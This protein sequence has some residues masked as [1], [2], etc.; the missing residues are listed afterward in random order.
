M[1]KKNL[2]IKKI[3]KSV[4]SITNRIESFFNF[5]KENIS[6]KKKFSKTLKTVDKRIF[7]IAATIVITITSYFLIPS[8]YDKDKIKAELENQIYDQYNLKV[9]FDQSLKYGLFPKPHFYKIKPFA[10]L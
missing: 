5:F 3:N 10:T 9:K 7:F 8:F 6:Y 4:L 2:F 1:L